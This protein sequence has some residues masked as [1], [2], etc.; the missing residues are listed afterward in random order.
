MY[1]LFISEAVV[2]EASRGDI[3]ASRRRLEALSG[4]EELAIDEPAIGLA[5]KL[6]ENGLIPQKAAADA[7]H[8][9]VAAI[10]EEVRRNRAAILESFGG[11]IGKMMRSLMAKQGSRGQKVVA[12]TKRERP[13][14][15]NAYPLREVGS[16][17]E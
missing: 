13:F 15:S 17:L 12:F 7:I 8:I 3:E 2:E 11:D 1:R 10:I 6:L 4:L 16:T 5:E 14:A 9:A